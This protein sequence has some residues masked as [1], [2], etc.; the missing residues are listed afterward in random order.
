MHSTHTHAVT[1][2]LIWE[3]NT[4]CIQNRSTA[5]RPPHQSKATEQPSARRG[6]F[7]RPVQIN[8]QIIVVMSDARCAR[9]T[10]AYENIRVSLSAS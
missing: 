3:Y 1:C 4:I 2:A 7:I 9:H 10:N 8:K 5:V 6:V